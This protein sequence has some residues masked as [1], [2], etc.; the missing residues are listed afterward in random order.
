LTVNGAVYY[1]DWHDVQQQIVLQCG[2][3]ITANFGG[4]TSKGAEIEAEYVPIAGLTFK[5]SGGYTD[6][7]LNNSI[8][9]SAAQKGDQLTDVPRWS[10]AVSGEYERPI[11]ERLSGFLRVDFTDRAGANALYDR[12]SPFYHYDG[13]AQTNMRLGVEQTERW[14]AAVFLDNAFNKIGETALPVA[15]AADLPTTRRIAVN[16]PRTVGLTFDYKF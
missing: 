4:A 3:N 9:G 16:T 14:T 13:F 12:T 6:A 15:I 11:S 5:A 1:I 2:F 10:A 8:P 7:T